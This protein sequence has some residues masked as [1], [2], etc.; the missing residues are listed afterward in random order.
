MWL[1]PS[2]TTP[3][4]VVMLPTG[5]R[6]M[7]PLP[8]R[9]AVADSAGAGAVV[10]KLVLLRPPALPSVRLELSACVAP[11]LPAE[12]AAALTASSASRVRRWEGAASSTLHTGEE[13][14]RQITRYTLDNW[15]C[16][17][18]GRERE[19]RYEKLLHDRGHSQEQCDAQVQLAIGRYD[20]FCVRSVS[21]PPTG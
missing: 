13:Q 16:Q 7:R 9:I 5:W 11:G 15:T 3:L 20:D 12:A 17:P 19:A 14:Y 6:A 10:L 1:P 8:A 2:S 4:S 21:S 18:P